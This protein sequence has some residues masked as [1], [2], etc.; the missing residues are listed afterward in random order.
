MKINKTI[1]ELDNTNK[2]NTNKDN[3][4]HHTPYQ[5]EHYIEYTKCTIARSSDEMCGF[6]AT[7]YKRI[8]G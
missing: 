7:K 6:M 1:K 8:K 4:I 3:N 5:V 2:D